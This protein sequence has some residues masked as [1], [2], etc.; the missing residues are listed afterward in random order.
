MET[1]ALQAAIAE[2]VKRHDSLR[3]TLQLVAGEPVQVV[4]LDLALPLT[5]FDLSQL[6]GPEG[7]AEARRLV[8]Q[9]ARRPFNLAIGPLFRTLLLNLTADDHVLMVNMHH[10]ITDGWSLGIFASELAVLYEAF[11]RNEPSPL[12]PLA[13]TYRDFAAWQRAYLA[14]G[15]LEEQ[16]SYWKSNMASA[17]PSIELPT[18]RVRP[19]I[20]TFNGAET[21]VNFPAELLNG[22]K[23]LSRSEGGTLFITLLAVFNLLLSR[24]SGQEDI[25]VGTA[26]AGRRHPET[27]KLVGFFVNTLALRTDMSGDPSFHDL[28]T[29]VLQTTL[30]AFANQ[31]VPF[32]KLVEELNPVRDMSRT[33]L[34]QVML[35]H[36]NA[37]ESAPAFE[38]LTAT[39][40]VVAKGTAKVDLLLSVSES[41]GQLR[42]ALE[43]NTDL[44]DASTIERMLGHY[45]TLLESA[46]ANPERRLSELE[47]LGT[48]ERTEILA[49]WNDTATAYPREKCVHELIEEQVARTPDRIAAVFQDLSLTYGDLNRRANQLAHRL[50]SMGVGPDTLVGVCLDRSLEMLV[51][52]LG[53]VKAGGAYLPVDTSF[54]KERQAFMLQDARV[55]VLLTTSK[56]SPNLPPHSAISICLDTEWSSIASHSM[57]NLGRI[58]APENLAYVLYT[59]GST[60]KPKGVMIT[61]R[62]LLNFLESMRLEPG[63]SEDD[64]LVAVTTLSFDIAGLELWLPLYVGAH[65]VIASREIAMD[66][67]QLAA[68]LHAS[69]ATMMQATPATWRLL[70]E[71]GWK[72]KPDLVVLCGGEALSPSL[73]TGMLPLCKQMWNMYGPTETTIWSTISRVHAN[74]KISLGH[75]IGNTQILIIDSHHRLTPIGVIGELCIGGDGLSRGY[76]NQA[77]LTG[78]RFFANPF[79]PQ[80][81]ARLYKTGDLARRLCDGS[82][83]YVGRSDH[84]VKIRG[85][86]I[87]LGEIEAVL[88]RHPLVQECVVLAREDEPGNKFLAAYLIPAD[89]QVR[90][91]MEELGSFI[92]GFLPDYMIPTG[93]MELERFPLTANGKVSRKAL[94]VPDQRATRG[95]SGKAPRTLVEIRLANIWEEVLKVSAVRVDDDFFSLGGHSLLAVQMMSRAREAF[96]CDLALTLLFSA[97]KL[98]ELANIIQTERGK[99]PFKMVIPIRKTG[100]KP[101]LFCISRPNVN[102]L[103]FIFLA[104]NLSPDQPVIG[105]Q[106][107]MEKDGSTWVYDQIEYESKATEYIK[108]MREDYPNGPYL[109]TGYCE[110]AHIAFE[111]ARQLEL[112]NLPVAMIAILDAWPIENTVSRTKF[113]LRGYWR[114]VRRFYR[115]GMKGKFHF[116]TRSVFKRNTR[117]SGKLPV[118]G[119]AEAN[120]RHRKLSAEQIEKRYWPGPDFVPTKYSGR[121]SLFRTKRQTNVRIGD[122]KMGWSERALGGV[123]VFRLPGR[124]ELILREPNVIKLAHDMQDCIDRVLEHAPQP[125]L[126]EQAFSNHLNSTANGF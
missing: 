81:G 53:V 18:D 107:Q 76:L 26:N 82:I 35:I 48:A 40:F 22:L 3:T 94:P 13:L 14:G 11:R 30:N 31:D 87:E 61:H 37:S 95:F 39:P 125:Q 27:E 108:A 98:G 21:I 78:E 67:E 101:P 69:G 111:M 97:P 93:W 19:P 10:A 113:I 15:A 75:P 23:S 106:S 38:S 2:I 50:Q 121:L 105:L 58:S 115:M 89:P 20:Q 118:D 5:I 70:L 71:T 63:M 85:F 124:H 90:F 72:G 4:A 17:P 56:L 68:L 36:Q 77:E 84:Q 92:K 33:P 1:A 46:V 88:A 109:L 73:V 34:F 52:I 45:R 117:I 74:Q 28:L 112:M 8:K 44:F 103:G 116:V 96:G 6:T 29:R 120:A 110:G 86:R 65:V 51:A 54:P 66:G 16:L 49:E 32:Q 122:Y 80:S 60:G 104:R 24:Y 57:E 7:E 43:Y 64:T 123:D 83:E 119:A 25:V 102:A 47:I 59:S 42:C 41:N 114:E 79:S 99:H 55:P 126:E 91:D 12:P 100:S 9:E 62:N